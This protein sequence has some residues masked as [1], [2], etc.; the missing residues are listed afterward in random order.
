MLNVWPTVISISLITFSQTLWM[1]IQL[2]KHWKYE[3]S[4]ILH[5]L[6]NF[7]GPGFIP[8]RRNGVICI[9][10]LILNCSSLALLVVKHPLKLSHKL[11]YSSLSIP[12][13]RSV[14]HSVL[15]HPNIF[16]VMLPHTHPI[17]RGA[18]V[19]RRNFYIIVMCHTN[20]SVLNVHSL[21]LQLGFAHIHSFC[22]N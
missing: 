11:S 14:S 22:V 18:T 5:L 15:K 16:A 7:E 9:Q 19:W 10:W 4:S 8:F 6:R 17:R 2:N 21:S 12:I 20:F 3:P 1:C 13:P